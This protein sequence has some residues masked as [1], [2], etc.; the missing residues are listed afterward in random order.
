MAGLRVAD[1]LGAMVAVSTRGMK[2]E[3][4]ANTF[5]PC[6]M[7]VMLDGVVMSASTDID[8]IIP[9]DVY[10]VEVFFGPSRIPPQYNGGRADQ[11][12]GLIAIWTRS[13]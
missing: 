2:W 4:G 8:Q 10:A 5:V 13:S 11:W 6:V 12:C 7:R 9:F 1:S 3:R